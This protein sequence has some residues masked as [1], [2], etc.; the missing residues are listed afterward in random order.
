M[1]IAHKNSLVNTFLSAYPPKPCTGKCN[2]YYGNQPRQNVHLPEPC[3]EQKYPCFCCLGC[4]ATGPQGPAGQIANFA[5]FY[6]LMPPD[7][8]ATVAP[9]TD[10][11]FPQDG[12]NSGAG[13]TRIGP[14]SFNLTQIG[15]YQ[16]LF[17]VSGTASKECH[18]GLAFCTERSISSM[19][20]SSVPPSNWR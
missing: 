1:F 18:R 10:V 13:I 3:C 19:I 9:G 16:I 20:Y 7:N 11:S 17:Q 5:D 12:P 4:G 8:A 14:S 6:A 15:S 2:H